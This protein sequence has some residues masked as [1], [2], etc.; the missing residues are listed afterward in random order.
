LVFLP[1]FYGPRVLHPFATATNNWNVSGDV[2][3]AVNRSEGENAVVA[4]DFP[5]RKPYLVTIHGDYRAHPIDPK[6]TT[7]LD[8]LS[9]V[10]G[11]AI[12][13]AFDF[14]T[15]NLVYP[16][17]SDRT[18]L[19]VAVTGNGHVD[20]Y[21]L[22]TDV[23]KGDHERFNVRVTDNKTSVSGTME[24]RSRKPSE[25]F[26]DVIVQIVAQDKHGK[27]QL[28]L[29]FRRLGMARHGHALSMLLPGQE[30]NRNISPEPM[31][32]TGR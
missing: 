11:N 19:T 3:Y 21:L 1:P 24:R 17:G 9:V 4:A 16:D 10:R 20:T 5:D 30:V 28:P 25:K 31:T 18:V 22:D 6:L 7:T 2:I 27:H 14:K 12:D 29:Y 32:V 13:L 23:S 15:P 26:S 8:K